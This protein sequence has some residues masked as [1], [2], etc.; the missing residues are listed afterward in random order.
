MCWKVAI[1]AII[2]LVSMIRP[3]QFSDGWLW[4]TAAW[5]ASPFSAVVSALQPLLGGPAHWLIRRAYQPGGLYEK[6]DLLDIIKLQR[7]QIDNRISDGDLKSAIG[8]LSF[9]D[10]TVSSVMVPRRQVKWVAANEVIG[11]LLMDELH[12]TGQTRF[13]VVKE[14][15][16][17]GNPQVVGTL[18]LKD[19][20]ENL[21]AK[22]RIRDIMHAGAHFINE[23]QNLREA[24]DG[25]LQAGQY[26]LI[27]TNNFEE[28]AGVISFE[29]VLEQILGEKI[30]ESRQ[31]SGQEP[32]P[33]VE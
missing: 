29:D 23:S 10:K 22:G 14:A 8:A 2:W 11:P 4:K 19:L 21:E 24:L 1:A 33:K 16:K 3:L 26:L 32:E 7:R 9:S 31:N 15:S 5:L 30:R 12:K 28:V 13:G 18:Y 6:E 20:L 25:F 27:V 17:S